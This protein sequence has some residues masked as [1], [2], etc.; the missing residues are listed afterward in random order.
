M[1]DALAFVRAVATSDGEAVQTMATYV[2]L[3]KLTVPVATV[4]VWALGQQHDRDVLAQLAR[5]FAQLDETGQ[6]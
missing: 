2:D 1:R 4:T 3:A 5:A 6:L